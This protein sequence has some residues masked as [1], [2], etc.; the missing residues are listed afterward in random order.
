MWINSNIDVRKGALVALL[1]LSACG[2]PTYRLSAEATQQGPELAVSGTSN[3]PEQALILVALVDPKA[4]HEQD[5]DV[6]VQQFALLKNG[7][8]TTRLKPLKPLPAGRYQL[9]LRFSP[10]SYSPDQATVQAAVGPKGEKL[11]GPQVVDDGNVKML[12]TTQEI[13]YKP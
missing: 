6:I 11:S 12:I 5:H 13:D 2:G 7:A 4:P 3:L 8:F 9:R 1:A 10:D